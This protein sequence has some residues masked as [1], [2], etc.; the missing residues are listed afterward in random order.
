MPN[1]FGESIMIIIIIIMIIRI[2][3][4]LKH[5]SVRSTTGI[6]EFDK[7]G[8]RLEAESVMILLT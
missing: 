1:R 7:W 3:D 2:M 5:Y 8:L 6:Y 4:F